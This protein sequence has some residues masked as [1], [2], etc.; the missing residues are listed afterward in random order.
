MENW[1]G[2][3]FEMSF[4]LLFLVV[5]YVISMF[6]IEPF[7]SDLLFALLTGNYILLLLIWKEL[8]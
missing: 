7:N 5:A 1:K 4:K 2:S 6:I 8:F 3:C